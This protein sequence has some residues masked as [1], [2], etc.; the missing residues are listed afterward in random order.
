MVAREYRNTASKF[1][2]IPKPLQ[3]G[4]SWRCQ[5]YKSSFQ[6]EMILLCQCF[7]IKVRRC[8]AYDKQDH[9]TRLSLFITCIR[10]RK[11]HNRSFLV[12][13]YILLDLD[14]K[15]TENSSLLWGCFRFTINLVL[16]WGFQN[17][18]RCLLDS[19][20]TQHTLACVARRFW[21]G[22]IDNKGGRGRGDWGGSCF[23]AHSRAA[24]KTM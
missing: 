13:L 2:Q 22:A 9:R 5:Y 6:I 21:L 7:Q 20:G 1:S 14:H 17:V 24:D 12:L 23:A 4:K 8:Q 10:L 11:W 3:M 16:C 18:D 19:K 15:R